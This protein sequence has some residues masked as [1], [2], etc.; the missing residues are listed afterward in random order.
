MQLLMSTASISADAACPDGLFETTIEKI[1]LASPPEPP[2]VKAQQEANFAVPIEVSRIITGGI[3]FF[4]GGLINEGISSWYA[5]DVARHLL[6]AVI[7]ST[8]EHSQRIPAVEKLSNNQIVRCTSAAGYRR[9]E[10]VTILSATPIQVRAFSCLANKLLATESDQAFPRPMRSD[11]MKKS[12][13]LLHHG[14]TLDVGQ[15]QKR[16]K[17]QEALE[18]SISQPLQQLILQAFEP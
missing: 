2:A 7:T 15:G 9:V 6:I 10:F 4:Q 3:S 17:I 12:F 14:Q 11:T 13:S 8:N 16:W 18:Y 5:F 1:S